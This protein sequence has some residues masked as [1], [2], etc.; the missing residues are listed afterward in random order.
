VALN[1]S[2]TGRERE[3]ERGFLLSVR[4]Y[5][6]QIML[7]L[8]WTKAL[9]KEYSLVVDALITYDLVDVVVIN[10]QIS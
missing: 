2:K 1:K 10:C 6:R 8:K 7:N 4:Q 9:I 3:R 5:Q